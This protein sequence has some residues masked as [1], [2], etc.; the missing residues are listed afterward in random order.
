MWHSHRQ[1]TDA[2]LPLLMGIL[3]PI[4]LLGVAYLIFLVIRDVI[5]DKGMKP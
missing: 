5:R 2:H 3:I 1:H 4:I